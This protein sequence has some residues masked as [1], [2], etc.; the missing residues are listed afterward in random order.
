MTTFNDLDFGPSHAW[1]KTRVGQVVGTAVVEG[2]GTR[3]WP[4]GRTLEEQPVDLY[5][6]PWQ[7]LGGNAAL[8]RASLLYLLRQLEELAGNSDQQPVYIGWTTTAAPGAF[9]AVDSHDGWYVVNLVQPPYRRYVVTGGTVTVP[10][11]VAMVAPAAPSALTLAFAGAP[12][13]TTYT[14]SYAI[15]HGFPIGA[16]PARATASRTGAEG[17]IPMSAPALFTQTP[18][19]FV[20]PGTLA[21]LWTG[22]VTCWDTINTASNPVPIAGAF[23][24][25]SW[26]KVYGTQH[27]LTGDLVVTNGLLLFLFQAGQGQLCTVYF[28]NTALGTPAWTSIGTLQYQD[29]AGNN[30]TLRTVDLDRVSFW[31]TRLHF[32]AST[33]AGNW[34]L[35]KLRLRGGHYDATVEFGPQ[36]ENVTNQLALVWSAASAYATGFT[37]AASSTTFPS[38]LSPTTLAGYAGAQGSA[39]NS[40]AFGFLYQNPPTTAQGRLSTSSLF[41]YG[42]TVGPTSGSYKTYG[43]FAGPESGAPVLAT[44]RAFAQESFAEFLAD[45]RN[46]RWTMG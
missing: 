44:S 10:M 41:G 26:V 7:G 33:S 3:I 43:I 14:T 32:S 29:N 1:L 30:G 31:E 18:N 16:V 8:T 34:S 13:S 23:V 20:R 37:D 39:T 35:F 15:E 11:T 27:N 17:A 46:A 25:S 21:A 12:L 36:S 24:N 2:S 40:P 19:L 6:N 9:S 45:V 42:D 22:G 5:V 4:R 38:N 28:W